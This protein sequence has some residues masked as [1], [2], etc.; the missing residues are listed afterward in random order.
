MPN[1]A[2]ET[3]PDQSRDPIPLCIDCDGTLIATDLLHESV[4]LLLKSAPWLIL[5]LPL[6][7]VRGRAALKAEL[8]ERVSLDPSTLPY[9]DEVLTLVKD[10]RAQQRMVVLATASHESA[11]ACVARHLGLFDEIIASTNTIN[12]K[13]RSKRDALV[14][15]F[16]ERGF[17]YAGDSRADLPV[18]SM[19][20][21]GI[22][23]SHRRDLIDRVASECHV[24]RVIEPAK[25]SWRDRLRGMRLH[26][27]LKNLL[28]FVPVLA[29]HRLSDS[30][31][32]AQGLFAFI[33]FGCCASAVY[34]LNDFVDLDSDR[35]HVRKR[36]RP[37]ASGLI[38]LSQGVAA[39]PLLLAVSGAITV[40]LLPAAFGA[41]LVTYFACTLLYSLWLKRQ[42]IVDVLILAGLYTL[43]VIAGGAATAIAPSFW[44][45]AFSMFIFLSLAMVKR[46]SE[47]LVTLQQHG[48]RAAGRGY[49]VQD[50]PVL[51]SI[52]C[53]SGLLAVLVFALYINSP[54]TH[55]A[56][57]QPLALWLVPPLLLY[58]VCR[59]W[60]KAHRGEVDDDPVVF[61][62]RDWQSAVIAAACTASFYFAAQ[63]FA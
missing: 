56:Y 61:A 43:R 32:M 18:W 1:H 49:T 8:A 26:Q 62:V 25:A 51:M 50:L 29:A 7:L 15:R 3:T 31:A 5:W 2:A 44:L 17:D 12:L 41:V 9:R 10:A 42:V 23:V 59:I 47:M 28:V 11:A 6:W 45:L 54:E 34:V 39:I 27:W 55:R 48:L 30:V 14:Q 40:S 20:R 33:A 63:V 57:A 21:R 13:G 52:G 16:G 24:E 38:P 35:R 36:K 4:L 46:Y 60:M 53:G 22:V 58:W 37:F 19:A